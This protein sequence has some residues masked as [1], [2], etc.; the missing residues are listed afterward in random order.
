MYFVFVGYTIQ[1]TLRL[2][3]SIENKRQLWVLQFQVEF[4][5]DQSKM[6]NGGERALKPIPVIV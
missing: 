3:F 5:K 2:H 1:M 6:V 4:M